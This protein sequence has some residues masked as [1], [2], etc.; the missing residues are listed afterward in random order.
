M[1]KCPCRSKKVECGDH[2]GCASPKVCKN[3]Q[4]K[5]KDN[6]VEG[7][8]IKEV[9][10]WGMDVATCYNIMYL[11]PANLD[12]SVKYNFIMNKIGRSLM[13]M[14]EEG[15][16]IKKSLHHIIEDKDL[17][18][19][20]QDKELAQIVLNAFQAYPKMQNEHFKIHCKGLGIK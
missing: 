19:T 18:F 5:D 3:R 20:S 9:I 12:F 13:C 2:C 4:I 17:S 14:G 11:L 15:W 6:I 8:D 10:S 16:D 1:S 7:R